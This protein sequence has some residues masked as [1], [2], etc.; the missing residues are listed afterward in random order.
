MNSKKQTIILIAIISILVFFVGVFAFLNSG[1]IAYKKNLEMNEIFDIRIGEE[2]IPVTMDD[3]V[4]LNPVE[5][6]AILDTSTTDPKDVL[7]RGV[8][9]KDIL[10][11]KHID[12]STATMFEVRSLDGYASAISVEEILNDNF[13]YICIAEGN[14]PLKTK[15]E[16]GWGPYLMIVK[17]PFSNRWCK[18]V[19]EIVI[20]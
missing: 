18:F 15:K 17:S 5:F 9:I 6:N 3:V 11:S 4:A 8:E 10:T 12:F 7:Y 2:R 20:R 16:G 13:A 14:K 1:D 19:Q